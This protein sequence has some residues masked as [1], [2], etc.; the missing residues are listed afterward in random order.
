[1]V[2]TMRRLVALLVAAPLGAFVREIDIDRC[3]S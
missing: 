2:S 3:G 1:M